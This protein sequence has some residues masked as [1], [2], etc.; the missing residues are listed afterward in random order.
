[1][2]DHS[3]RGDT[4]EVYA[5]AVRPTGYVTQAITRGKVEVLVPNAGDARQVVVHSAGGDI[6]LPL[7]AGVTAPSAPPVS[8][9]PAPSSISGSADDL[10]SDYKNALGSGTRFEESEIAVLFSLNSFATAADLYAALTSSVSD[11]ASVRAATLALAKEARRTDRILT[12]T[13][14]QPQSVMTKWDAIRQ[15]VLKLMATYNIKSH[16]IE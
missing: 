12:T 13:G 16:E 10:F 8:S 2:A 4:I 3:V 11:P 5:K 9:V 14:N 15:D 1:M 7:D 6:T